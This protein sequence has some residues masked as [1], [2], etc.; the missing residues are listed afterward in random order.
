MAALLNEVLREA[1]AK[2]AENLRHHAPKASGDL[3]AGFSA[4]P[5]ARGAVL[6]NPV[7]YSG[8]VREFRGAP[9][10]GVLAYTGVR[11][12]ARRKLRERGDDI[13]LRALNDVL[14]PIIKRA[15][16]NGR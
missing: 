8:A 9:P 6:R 4:S 3:R 1:A 5:T 12:I 14:A 7:R 16:S 13:A 10:V 15:R 11:D 2:A